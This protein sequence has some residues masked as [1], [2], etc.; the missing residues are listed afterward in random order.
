[1]SNINGYKRLTHRRR[2]TTRKQLGNAAI[3]TLISL[4]WAMQAGAQ[5]TASISGVVRDTTDALVPGAKVTLVNEASKASRTATSNGEGFFNF[6]AVQP[7]TY[8]I[9]VQMKNFESWR[10]TGIEVHPGDSLVVP[11]IQLKVGAATVEVTVTATTAGVSLNSPEHSTLITADDIKRLS[12]VGRDAAE[13]V[14]ILPGFSISSGTSIQNQ[15]PDYSVTTFGGN[16]GAYGANGAAPQQGLVNITSDGAQIIDPGDMGASDAN[17]NMDQVQEIKVQT[18]NF[19]ADEAKGPIVINAVGKSGGSQYHGSVYGYLRNA[20]LNSND[21]LSKYEGAARTQSRYAYP[22]ANVGGPVKI[23]GTDFNRSKRLVFWTSYEQYV[24]VQNANNNSP[25]LAFIPTPAMLSGDL[26]PASLGSALNVP[27]ADLSSGCAV[28][29]AVSGALSDLGGDCVSPNNVLD[30]YGHTVTG[31]MLNFTDPAVGAFTKWYP[32]I[33][34]VPKP[35][36]AFESD[37]YNYVSN[38][39]ATHNGFQSHSRVDESFSDTLK[40]YATFNWEK[41]NDEGPLNNIYYNPPGTIPYPTPHYSHGDSKVG[42]I[43]LT[44]TLGNTLTNELVATGVYFAEPQQFGNR[45]LVQDTGTPWG[46]AGYSGG[47]L[48]NG[49]T[50]LPRIYSYETIGIPNFSFG[51]VPP[52]KGEFLHKSAWNISDN[53]TKVIRTHTIK[54]GIYDEQTRNNSITLG[55]DFNGTI[56]VARWDGCYVN[57]DNIPAGTTVPTTGLS[58]TVANF[59]NGCTAGYSQSSFDPND[60]VYF[61]SLEGYGTDEWKVNSKLTLTYGLRI[62]HLPP[63]T[64][65]HGVGAAVWDPSVLTPGVR[66]AG[67]TADTR[68]WQGISWHQQNHSIPVSG[69][70]PHGLFY[71]PRAGLAYDLYGNGKTTFRGGFGLYRS[72]D[73]VA[74]PSGAINTGIDLVD[75]VVAGQESCTYGQLFNP[76]GA[77]TY[78]CEHYYSSGTASGLPSAAGQVTAYALNRK[79]NQQP[80][81]YNY[82]FTVDQQLPGGSNFEI[83][84]IGNQSTHL[85]TLGNLQ[86]VNVIPLGAF[87]GPDPVTGETNPP[88][89]ISS[90]LSSDY[91]P[92]PNYEQVYVPQHTNWANY[93]ALQASINKQRGA[94]IYGVNYTWAKSLAVRGN[95][96]TGNIADPVNP[97]HDYGITAFD[98]RQ[99]INF[100][101]SYQEGKKFKGTRLLQ[102]VLNGWEIS[103]ITTLTSGPDLSIYDGTNFGFSAQAGYYVQGSSGLTSISVPISAANYLGS[104]DYSLQPTVTCDPR[105]NLHSSI[106]TST[107]VART[108]HQFVNGNCFAVPKPG[109]QGWWNLP[110]TQGPAFFK[111]DLSLYKD[112]QLTEHQ[113]LQFRMAGFNFLNHP[114]TSF[115]NANLSNLNLTFADPVCTTTSTTGCYTSQSAAFAGEYMN[116]PNFGLSYYKVGQRIVEFGLKYNF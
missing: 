72:H 65:A 38:P 89:Q 12:T 37:G 40:L 13:L 32:A 2:N 56:T 6:L 109:T 104:S 35:S 41:V 101:Y 10:V 87:F 106:D 86:N 81:T 7:A 25:L 48:K 4:L 68:T 19:G 76:A 29:Y 79:D 95:Y 20:A 36:G 107:G 88:A 54:F 3:L 49:D 44:K 42:S 116:N 22:G 52:G 61:D 26:S 60:D 98:R 50:Q 77:H 91:R 24:Q 74:F 69:I 59:L 102:P 70:D 47:W 9:Q 1:M 30:A 34:R 18:S 63:W 97:H 43:N 90:P 5:Q 115:N 51:Y 71:S 110:D 80:L 92:Y 94:L 55:S 84:Y 111:S 64:D 85:S 53:V 75:H 14:S 78:P 82:N 62:S 27:A 66:F 45:S 57:E 73:S 15:G 33:N 39:T 23:P 114:I 103:G 96:D 11:K 105:L 113:Q 108:A 21:W 99:A 58:N 93:N 112:F 28:D 100:T 8:A 83:A 46:A 16:L 31:G 67:M 17:I